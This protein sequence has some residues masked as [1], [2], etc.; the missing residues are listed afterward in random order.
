MPVLFIRRSVRLF[1]RK[2][3]VQT[4]KSASMRI[5][6]ATID[7]SKV[8]AFRKS[9]V[10]ITPEFEGLTFFIIL[11]VKVTK[12]DDYKTFDKIS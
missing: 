7:E 1:P 11:P 10:P 2:D 9:A 3:I 8:E 6:S 12:H 4:Q 5:P